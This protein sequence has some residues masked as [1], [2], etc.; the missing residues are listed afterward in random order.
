MSIQI[1]YKNDSG[2]FI[3]EVQASALESFEKITYL[4]GAVKYIELTSPT[5]GGGSRISIDHFMSSGEQMQDILDG[6]IG[7][8]TT[9]CLYFNKQTNLSFTS[10][11]YNVYSAEG[12]LIGK[13][14]IVYDFYDRMIFSGEL[15]LQTEQLKNTSSKIYYNPLSTKEEIHYM[16]AYDKQGNIEWINDFKND[17][18]WAGGYYSNE[19]QDIGSDP[20]I[21]FVWDQHP[22]YHSA[23]P[24][25]PTGDL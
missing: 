1:K 6:Y 11:D 10:W 25:L 9:V 12:V 3:P 19:F 15:D 7:K 13:A 14:T 16:F 22:Y 2:F 5:R 17:D 24:F 18:T 20:L 8:Y 4:D 21:D 23:Y